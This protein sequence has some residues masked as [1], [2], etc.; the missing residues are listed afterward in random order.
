MLD[1]SNSGTWPADGLLEKFSEGYGRMV[2]FC[3]GI[4]TWRIRRGS[5]I[6]C[7]G[8]KPTANMY[9]NEHVTT[10][11][12]IFWSHSKWGSQKK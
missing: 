5:G 2:I 10:P 1:L 7:F 11:T 9:V 3:F 8:L 4:F 6:F 12:F